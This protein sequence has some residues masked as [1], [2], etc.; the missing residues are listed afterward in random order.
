MGRMILMTALAALLV[1][2]SGCMETRIVGDQG[3]TKLPEGVKP[4][5]EKDLEDSKTIYGCI[6]GNFIWNDWDPVKA[7]NGIGLYQVTCHTDALCLLTSTCTLGA[8]VP[9]TVTWRLQDLKPAKEEV[10]R[11]RPGAESNGVS[12]SD[13][14]LAG[15]D[16]NAR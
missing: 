16:G 1:V 10:K 5:P 2:A 6:Y 11:H 9:M 13:T 15:K 7:H 4:I 3:M 14:A 12:P 8:V